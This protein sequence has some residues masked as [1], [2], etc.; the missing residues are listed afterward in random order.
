MKK[1]LL[2]LIILIASF[3][4]VSDAKE[5]E[6]NIALWK[7]PLNLPAIAALEDRAYEKN[8][9]GERKVNYIQLPS[10]PKQIQ[11]IGA[12]QLDIGEGLGAPAVLVGVAAGVDL[13][14][15]G[16]CSR[17]PRGFAIVA[18]NPA[19]KSVKDLRGKK[20]AGIRGSV[21]HQLY[22]ELIDEAGLTDGDVDFFPMTLPAARAALLAGHVDAALLVGAEI[23]RAEKSGARVIADGEG[24]L[25]GLSLIVAGSKFIKQNPGAVEKFLQVRKGILAEMKTNSGRFI[26][27][28]AK[29]ID[30]TENEA[31]NIIT[32]Y[33]FNDKITSNDILELNKTMAYLKKMKII[34]AAIDIIRIIY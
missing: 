16:I 26:A 5:K 17:S 6:I 28:T 29:E 23:I 21:V 18:K 31:R 20:I 8:F 22:S 13:K 34:E 11:A 2:L 15:I 10:G 27:I 19:I 24:R 3:T 30:M 25:A 32:W 33:D 14:I 1:S 12:G 7:L 4:S 9:A